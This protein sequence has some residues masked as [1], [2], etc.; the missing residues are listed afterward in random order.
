MTILTKSSITLVKAQDAWRQPK[1]HL[2]EDE[3]NQWEVAKITRESISLLCGRRWR[4]LSSLLSHEDEA[5][6]LS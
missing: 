6:F 4:E 1:G 3:R 5:F 2:S